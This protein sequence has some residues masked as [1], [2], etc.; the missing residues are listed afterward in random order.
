MFKFNWCVFIFHFYLLLNLFI[1]WSSLNLIW[2]CVA[3]GVFMQITIEKKEKQSEFEGAQ[4][5]FVKEG[6]NLIKILAIFSF[7]GNR[8]YCAYFC[9]CVCMCWCVTNRKRITMWWEHICIVLFCTQTLIVCNIEFYCSCEQK[10]IKKPAI[11]FGKTQNKHLTHLR[12][13]MRKRILR[14]KELFKKF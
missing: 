3:C 11:S 7:F 1:V 2:M 5:G 6:A 14:T 13:K 10:I 12:N 4:C 9:I 8:F